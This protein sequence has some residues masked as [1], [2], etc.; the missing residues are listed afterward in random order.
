MRRLR[1]QLRRLDRDEEGSSLIFAALT[2]FSLALVIMYVYQI[3]LVTTDRIQI[4]NAADAAAYSAAQVEANAL[5][6]IG[7][8]N[9]A[10][11]YLNYLLLR[12]TIDGVVYDTLHRFEDVDKPGATGRQGY[13]LMGGIGP[14]NFEGSARYDHAQANTADALAK[15]KLWIEDM[16]HVARAI[17]EVTPELVK[18]TAT[19]VAEFNGASHI[20]ISD[21]V[22]LAFK[23]DDGF[24]EGGTSNTFPDAMYKRY[25]EKDVWQVDAV[26]GGADPKSSAAP[27]KLTTEWFDPSKGGLKGAAY[28]QVRL[29]W[30]ENDWRH[31]GHTQ[32][33][34]YGIYIGY[35]AG[36]PNNHWHNKH[37][38][39]DYISNFPAVTPL[40]EH[41]GYVGGTDRPGAHWNYGAVDD[42]SGTHDQA[43]VDLFINYGPNPDHHET[44]ACPTCEG[45]Y[46]G[47]WSG[48]KRESELP[49]SFSL[50]SGGFFPRPLMI[51]TPLL[52]SGITVV[53]WREG[54]GLGETFRESDWGMVAVASAAVGYQIK[55]G[56]VLPLNTIGSSTTNFVSQYSGTLDGKAENR[57]VPTLT[58]AGKDE[59][60]DYKNLYYSDTEDSGVRFGA[61]LVPI[62][63]KYTQ[64][65]SHTNGEGLS[66]LLNGI[67]G[68]WIKVSD[69]SA[70]IP[71]GVVTA[72]GG[73]DR[74]T[75]KDVVL[76][77]SKTSLESFWH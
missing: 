34:G 43:I 66:D 74:L 23:L 27:Q 60:A 21:D 8:V 68:R 37:I 53:T 48:V 69:S 29:C 31:D 76:V 30:N 19:K 75:L 12:Y 9:D 62:A 5:N 42:D 26:S 24:A 35:R 52:Q 44:V 61:R 50:Y 11:A 14:T 70:E 4:Q 77:N 7:Q 38:H 56:G 25:E 72:R 40:P 13:V 3:G 17:M 16:H 47:R 18:R 57:G 41:G 33:H 54:H 64:H 49:R 71:P 58:N 63:H 32:P 51:K 45:Q 1:N 73:P 2:L 67:G 28:S 36:A 55:D 59:D 46:G 15:G 20:A 6:S 39:K 65:P 22:E 10:M